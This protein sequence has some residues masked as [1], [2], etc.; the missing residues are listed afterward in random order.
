MGLSKRSFSRSGAHSS[1][2]RIGGPRRMNQ[3][4]MVLHRRSRGR[5]G[6]WMTKI[7]VCAFTACGKTHREGKKRQGKNHGLH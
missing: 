7:L 4:V 1:S 6:P 5:G 2:A 3:T